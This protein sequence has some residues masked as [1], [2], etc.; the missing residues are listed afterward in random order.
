MVGI[1]PCCYDESSGANQHAS[2]LDGKL[3]EEARA[4]LDHAHAEPRHALDR[5]VRRDR[6]DHAM[7]VVMHAAVVDLRLDHI[8]A[9]IRCGAD[10]LG[11]LASGEQGF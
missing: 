9:E 8:D 4:R 1:D 6:R 5:V 10:S 7:H 11:A 2:G 3:V